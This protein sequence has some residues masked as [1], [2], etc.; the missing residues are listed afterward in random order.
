M[1][2]AWKSIQGEKLTKQSYANLNAAFGLVLKASG[3]IDEE[4]EK[5]ADPTAMA[6]AAAETVAGKPI[7]PGA[8][9]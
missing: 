1:D 5:T 3:L 9:V 4:A 2:G 8:A 7:C 6:Q